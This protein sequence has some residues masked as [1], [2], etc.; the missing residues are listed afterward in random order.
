[1]K[2]HLANIEDIYSVATHAARTSAAIIL[3]ALE[4]PRSVEHK[5]RTDLVTQTDKQSE[6]NIIAIIQASFP[7]HDIL[8]EESGVTTYNSK[9]LW[10]I[11]P[12]DGTTN[13][14]HGYPSFGVSIAVFYQDEPIVAVIAELPS[15]RLFSAIKGKGAFCDNQPISV[16]NNNDL[17]KSL[18]VTGFGY[19]HSEHWQSNM[20]LF[21][22][23]TDITQGVRRLGA[24]SIDLCHVALGVVDGFWE[25][26]LHPWDTAA[27]IL[28]VEEAGGKITQ[29]NGN[30]YSIYDDSIVAS[31]GKLHN[32]LVRTISNHLS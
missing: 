5:G 14:V 29:M 6:K 27:G 17:E 10:V 23:F 22:T 11:D 1:M 18:L 25:Y 3:S 4:L 31:N 2:L 8:A 15:N 20:S 32:S 7:D 21:K 24:A 19:E 30:S 26:D 28:I 9:Y 12:L 16:S 13:F